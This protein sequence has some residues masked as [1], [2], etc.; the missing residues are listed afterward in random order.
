MTNPRQL[1]RLLCSTVVLHLLEKTD[2]RSRRS[3]E[4]LQKRKGN[5]ENTPGLSPSVTSALLNSFS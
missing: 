4:R 1:V 2:R 5:W 3:Q